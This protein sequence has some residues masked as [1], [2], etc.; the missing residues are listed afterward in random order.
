MQA[1]QTSERL[2]GKKESLPVLS[3]LLIEA[4]DRC[5]MRATNLEAGIEVVLP[6]D[7]KEKGVAAVPATIF[8]QTIRAITG[9]TVT[10]SAE[11]GNVRVESRGTKTLIKSVP[12]DEFPPIGGSIK[13]GVRIPRQD[14]IKGI[15]SVSYAASPSMIRPEL[16]SILIAFNDGKMTCVATDSFRLAE[17]T[18]PANISGDIDDVLIPLKHAGELT[19]VLERIGGEAAEIVSDDSQITVSGDGIRFVSRV[20]DGAFPNYRDIIPKEVMATATILKADLSDTLRKARVFA[21]TESQVGFHLYPKKKI[22]TAT[23]Q[24]QQVGEMSDTIDAALS[25]ED[26]DI[27]FHIGYVADCLSAIPADSVTMSFAGIGRPLVIRG[28]SDTS[29]LY[30]VMP[31]N[32]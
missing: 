20:V 2:V 1:I 15:Q 26:V 18:L 9:D 27:N 14:L 13:K 22:F 11:D 3:C 8:S 29:F 24:S 17:K 4:S 21:G 23:A 25:G 10:L 32:R 19:H 7:I 31:L 28:V 6:C 5:V 12:H 30:L 16:G